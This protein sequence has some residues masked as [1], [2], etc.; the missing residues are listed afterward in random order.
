MQLSNRKRLVISEWDGRILLHIREYYSKEGK[1]L[2]GKG[3]TLNMEQVG[4][5][6][7]AFPEALEMLKEK[8]VELPDSESADGK[9]E[10]KQVVKAEK[11]HEH[12]D[13]HD[14]KHDDV[15]VVGVE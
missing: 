11:V 5:L 7:L 4:A 14:D 2:P 9:E 13:T 1:M 10:G 6:I 8:R 3:V 12:E 15:D